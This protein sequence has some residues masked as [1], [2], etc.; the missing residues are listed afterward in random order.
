MKE[1]AAAHLSDA[2]AKAIKHK[3]EMLEQSLALLTT[4]PKRRRGHSSAPSEL[5]PANNDRRE[6]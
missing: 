3:I 5:P 2:S 1:R 4:K 6:L